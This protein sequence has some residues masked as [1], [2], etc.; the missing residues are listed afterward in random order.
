MINLRGRDNKETISSAEPV[1]FDAAELFLGKLNNVVD[2]YRDGVYEYTI[3]HPVE[4]E[5]FRQDRE[6]AQTMR[7][8]S[9]IPSPISSMLVDTSTNP[10]HYQNYAM[11]K[12]WLEIM[13]HIPR[14]RDPAIFKGAVELNVRKY[15]DRLGGKDSELKELK[16]ALKYL[17]ILTAFVANDN[18]PIDFNKLDEY[19]GEV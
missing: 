11:G 16:K 10:S 13:Q 5:T 7:S 14:Y 6:M 19:I 12:Q 8:E 18:K 1:S 3:E 17:K 9:E 4:L 15:L 2:V